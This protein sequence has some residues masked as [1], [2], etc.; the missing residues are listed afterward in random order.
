MRDIEEVNKYLI[1]LIFY[2]QKYTRT[3]IYIYIYIYIIK[4]Q[5]KRREEFDY[6]LFYEFRKMTFS[7]FEFI[8][9]VKVL[10]V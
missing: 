6:L 8:R 4:K 1:Y 10:T 5:G 3:Y 9:L 2:I 7:M